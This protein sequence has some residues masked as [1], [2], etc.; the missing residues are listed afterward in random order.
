M[1]G[2]VNARQQEAEHRRKWVEGWNDL[3][4]DIWQE[5]IHKLRIEDTFSLYR[6]LCA[7]DIRVHDDGRFYDFSVSQ[8]FLEYGLWQE[9]GTGREFTFGNPGDIKS[10]DE[11]Y[12]EAHGLN[13][14]RKRGP[15]WGGGYTS[16]GPRE[17]RP[18]MS[19]KYYRSVMKLRDYMADSLG[20]EFKAMVCEALDSDNL[21]WNSQHY[22]QKGYTRS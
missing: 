8:T 1:A 22:K 6:S 19:P 5:R 17:R 7:L 3:M 14:P 16:G 11:E 4:I 21:R 12:R 2:T 10:Q 20:D 15:R 9:L 18:W 13:E